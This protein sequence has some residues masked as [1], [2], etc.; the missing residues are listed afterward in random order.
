[1]GC[2]LDFT[3]SSSPCRYLASQWAWQFHYYSMWCKQEAQPKLHCLHTLGCIFHYLKVAFKK[4]SWIWWMP[5]KGP[6]LHSSCRQ[7]PCWPHLHL[8]WETLFPEV[9]LSSSLNS[10]YSQHFPKTRSP[11]TLLKGSA[12]SS[13]PWMVQLLVAWLNHVTKPG[14]SKWCLTSVFSLMVSGARHWK[15]IMSFFSF[16]TKH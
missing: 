9:S 6:P 13:R 8:S 15:I 5:L 3:V 16:F 1:M 12:K 7:P 4:C 10:W 11:R 2:G 14:C